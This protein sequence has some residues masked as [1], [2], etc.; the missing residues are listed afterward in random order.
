MGIKV[1]NVSTD[2]H[3]VCAVIQ[4]IV[5]QIQIFIWIL[6]H[7]K[8]ITKTKKYNLEYTAKWKKKK[9]TRTWFN[10]SFVR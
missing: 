2:M 7:I 8:I 4:Y 1:E 9:K 3:S 6:N 5:Q 10:K